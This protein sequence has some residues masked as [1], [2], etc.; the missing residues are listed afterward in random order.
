MA[1]DAESNYG[2]LYRNLGIAYWNT[3]EDGEK[4]RQAFLKAVELVP[5][6]MR[7]RYEFDQLRKKLNDDP[8]DRLESLLPSYNFV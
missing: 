2:T 4:A 3:F 5:N 7:V 1:A 8:K 6:D